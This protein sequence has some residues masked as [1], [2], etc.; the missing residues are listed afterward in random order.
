MSVKSLKRV[1]EKHNEDMRIKRE[2]LKQLINVR[3][4]IERGTPHK[5]MMRE[6]QLKD[7]REQ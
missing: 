3:E 2:S 4:A 1:R 5:R 6:K 7:V